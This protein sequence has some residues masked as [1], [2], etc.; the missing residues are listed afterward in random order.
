MSGRGA[1]IRDR[2]GRWI[3]ASAG[4]TGSVPGAT[5]RHSRGSENPPAAIAAMED[6]RPGV[7]AQSCRQSA[8]SNTDGVPADDEDAIRV[9]M[10]RHGRTEWNEKGRIQGHTD[11]PLS[12]AGRARLREMRIPAPYRGFAWHSS[13]L[14]RAVQSAA[15]LGATELSVDARLREM[16]WGDWE[17]ETRAEIRR[18]LGAEMERMEER[19]IDFRPSGGESPRELMQRLNEWLED[20]CASLPGPGDLSPLSR[21]EHRGSTRVRV[22]A[23]YHSRES[24]NDGPHGTSRNAS[25]RHSRDSG[26]DS[27]HGTDRNAT[28]RHSRESGNPRETTS[29]GG[30]HARGRGVIALTHKGVIRAALALATGWDLRGS[31]PLRLDW[32]RAHLFALRDGK[33]RIEDMNIALHPDHAK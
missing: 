17:G 32:E 9:L 7:G 30:V 4:M 19:G 21:K 26:N 14:R 13:P 28:N 27:P 18:R 24:G 33:L 25:N 8:C 20:V 22:V 2:S 3:P 10:V 6:Q 1:D 12:E 11:I 16:Q 29:R 23:S 5:W 15:L 31:A